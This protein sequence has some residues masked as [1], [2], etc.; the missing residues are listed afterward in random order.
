[1]AS[2]E[3]GRQSKQGGRV[4]EMRTISR[5]VVG[6]PTR[7]VPVAQKCLQRGVWHVK[8]S[9]GRQQ[10]KVSTGAHEERP[11]ELKR[12]DVQYALYGDR[13]W[14]DWCSNAP[15]VKRYQ[16]AGVGHT[17]DPLA[18]YAQVVE[19]ELDRTWGRASLGHLR[20]LT[21]FTGASLLVVTPDEAQRFLTQILQTPGPRALW[22]GKRK[23]ATR[24]RA[25]ASCRRFYGW[26]VR[27][28]RCATNP[29]TGIKAIP[30]QRR[31]GNITYCVGAERDALLAAADKERDGVAVWVAFLAGLRREEIMRLQWDDVN[32]NR[33]LLIARATK[34]HTERTVPLN[35]RLRSKF[36]A[37]PERQRR[38]AVVPWQQDGDTAACAAI[39]ARRVSRAAIYR[40]PHGM[41][42]GHATDSLAWVVDW[43]LWT[44]S[45]KA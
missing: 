29:F 33:G 4:R 39:R 19:A 14:P 5:P 28:G 22:R 38:G 21:K 16:G 6:R 1:M 31:V 42:L 32:L 37:V 36:E 10:Y 7:D 30:E 26:A 2:P 45:R 12:M 44:S 40:L 24:N 20:E 34:T 15:A 23:P 35:H 43:G 27:T 18:D 11:A 25:L 8:W 9:V 41:P 17:G 13:P 3:R